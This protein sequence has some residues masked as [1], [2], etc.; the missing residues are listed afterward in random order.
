MYLCCTRQKQDVCPICL[1]KK[2]LT[3][4]CSIC[5]N[6]AI[7]QDCSLSLCE[8]GL[9]GKCPVC[10]QPNWKQSSN[11][12]IV[13]KFISTLKSEQKESQ[14]QIQPI[15]NKK[16]CFNSSHIVKNKICIISVLI[17]KCLLMYIIGMFTVLVFSSGLEWSEHGE[18]YWVSAIIGFVWTII[19]WSPCCCGKTLY[20]VFCLNKI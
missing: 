17:I 20:N 18:L 10:R 7:C 2:E 13:P 4:K 1:Q 8:K 15:N 19:I 6:T 3:T 16:N 5:T 14:Q 11:T 9:C 12:R